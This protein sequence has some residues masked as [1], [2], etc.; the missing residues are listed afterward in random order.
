MINLSRRFLFSFAAIF[1]IAGTAACN[2]KST[3]EGRSAIER[4][5]DYAIGKPDAPVTIIEFAS[6]TCPACAV[7]HRSIYPELKSRYIETGHVRFVFR[8]FPTPPARLAIGAEAIARCK[9]GSQNYFN[10]IDAL[11]E[12]QAFWLRSPTPGQALRDIA[13][14]AG[15]TKEQFD[16]CLNDPQNITRIQDVVKHANE[17]WGVTGTPSFVINGELAV[18]MRNIDDFAKIIDPLIAKSKTTE[19]DTTEEG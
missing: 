8:Q 5:D 19:P 10:L 9:G 18:N 2:P 7:F 13:S 3:S 11:F 12:K 1:L 15:I 14:T 4:D 6:S 17:T 16:A